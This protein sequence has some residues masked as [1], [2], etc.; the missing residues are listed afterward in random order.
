MIKRAHDCSVQIS[1]LMKPGVQKGYEVSDIEEMNDLYT[2][3][4]GHTTLI[5]GY[6]SSGKS[7]FALNLQCS[8]YRKHGLKHFIY[9]PEMGTAADIYLT[10]IEII[11]GANRGYGLTQ[12]MVDSI[13]PTVHESFFVFDPENSP[14]MEAITKEVAEG[15]EK[16]GY[17]TF[18]IDNMNDLSHTITGTQDIYFEQQLLF[19]NLCA[20]NNNLHGY[21]LV[22][23]GKPAPDDLSYPPTPD[24]IKGGSAFWSKGQSILS[25]KADGDALE[26]ACHK[27]KPRQVAKKGSVFMRVDFKRNTFFKPGEN[28]NTYFFKQEDRPEPIQK[29]ATAT[30]QQSMNYMIEPLKPEEEPF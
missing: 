14:T 4:L 24:K 26:V 5:T 17:H 28:G 13:L 15:K 2:S 7:F 25:L 20:K 29:P 3:K 6:P 30:V 21:L 16:C 23:P 10:L 18:L 11:Y 19:F 27:A 22:H 9:T 8:L 12:A 1:E